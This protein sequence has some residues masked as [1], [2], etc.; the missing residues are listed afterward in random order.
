MAQT[1]WEADKMWAFFF[2]VD[3]T[4]SGF[5]MLSFFLCLFCFHLLFFLGFDPLV[6]FMVERLELLLVFVA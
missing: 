3:D 6:F 4:W 1:N 2:L 5:W